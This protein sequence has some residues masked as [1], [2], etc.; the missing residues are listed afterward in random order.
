MKNILLLLIILISFSCKKDNV[1]LQVTTTY[2]NNTL[3]GTVNTNDSTT[4][5]FYIGIIKEG[6][7]TFN[8]MDNYTEKGIGGFTYKPTLKSGTS[9][10]IYAFAW[11][12]D[13]NAPAIGNTILINN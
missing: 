13:E 4:R 9:Y 1:S 6:N 7:V 10:Y 3:Y 2:T 8:A 11:K 5:G 12:G